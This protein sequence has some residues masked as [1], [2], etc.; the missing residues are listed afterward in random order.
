MSENL[1]GLFVETGKDA[2]RNSARSLAG[3]AQ[4]TATANEI[5]NVVLKTV[6]E[7]LGEYESLF[8]ASKE[9]HGAMDQLI[10][11]AYDLTT[12]DVSFLKTLDNDTIEGML[13]SQQS[14]R[15]RAKSAVMTLD[16]YRTMLIGAICEKIL[17]VTFEKPKQ[18]MNRRFSS[19]LE[20]TQEELDEFA[21]DQN[22]L[23]KELRN[24]Q[25]RKSIMKAKDDFSE[26]DPMWAALLRAEGKLK[27][28][29]VPIAPDTTKSQLVSLFN[30]LDVTSLKGAEAKALIEKA[31]GIIS[32]PASEEVANG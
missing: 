28:L 29:R 19:S 18:A 9:N 10:D 15:S 7:N 32:K 20:F 5:A 6:T 24:I 25:S 27:D 12:V 26:E 14:K 16:N 2:V 13:K 22:L 31:V 4:L 30:G 17:R 21:A 3:T 1:K 23:R 8:T 11:R